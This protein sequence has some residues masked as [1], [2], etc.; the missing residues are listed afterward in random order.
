[1]QLLYWTVT[2]A[3]GRSF[4]ADEDVLNRSSVVIL[5]DR[6]WRN[7]FSA[8]PAILGRTITLDQRPRTI[9]GVLP[10]GFRLPEALEFRTGRIGLN[11]EPEIFL[12]MEFGATELADIVG[13]F[14]YEVIGRLA[15]GIAAEQ[16]SYRARLG[17]SMS[18]FA[19]LRAVVNR[20]AKVMPASTRPDPVAF[21]QVLTECTDK[22]AL[23]QAWLLT[24]GA[25]AGLVSADKPSHRFPQGRIP[26]GLVPE[27]E[28]L[29]TLVRAV[30]TVVADVAR[31][32]LRERGLVR[33][34]HG[35]GVI[36]IG[37]NVERRPDGWHAAS[38]S[39]FRT[40]RR[41]MDGSV[42]VPER[43]LQ[44]RAWFQREAVGAAR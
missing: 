9:V 8:D 24:D 1:M 40:A 44:G 21:G 11:A 31:P 5:A 13:R 33:I 41:V 16:F 35:A 14:N 2:P 23:L 30:S 38:V 25:E 27:C 10:P 32:G 3:L 6:I 15:P 43:Y 34:A 17:A 37:V 22:L 18:L 42:Y 36:E 19:S 4:S 7:R 29:G 39:A 26:A 28:Q 12:P 20:H